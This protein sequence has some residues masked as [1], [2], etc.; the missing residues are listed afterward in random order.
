M[1]CTVYVLHHYYSPL[2]II[3]EPL[4]HFHMEREAATTV[5]GLVEVS[6]LRWLRLQNA[7]DVVSGEQPEKY[8]GGVGC[9]GGGESCQLPSG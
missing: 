2:Q 3:T 5:R 1:L 9:Q 8:T 7:D 6:V 4:V